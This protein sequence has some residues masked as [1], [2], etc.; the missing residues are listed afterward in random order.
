MGGRTAGRRG[1]AS[2]AAALA[3]SVLAASCSVGTRDR[4]TT[5]AAGLVSIG[6]GLR[7]PAGLRAA[8][9]ATRLTSVS[10]LALDTRGRL[11]VATSS[12]SKHATDAVYVVGRAGATPVRV[13]AHVRGPLGLLWHGGTLYVASIGRVDAFSGLRGDRFTRR[14]RILDG[15]VPDGWNN[16]LVWTPGGRILMGVSTTCDDCIPRSRWAASIVSFRPDGSQLRRYAT[17]IRDGF[18]LAR[19]PASTTLLV[20]MNQRDDLGA[21]TPGDWLGL[22][23]RGEDWGFP[24]CYGQ[25]GAVCRGV[26][27]P[28]AV[29]DPHAAAGG[30]G[31]VTGELGPSVGTAALVAEWAR[32]KVVRVALQAGGRASGVSTSTFL[33]GLTSPLPVLVDRRADTLFVGDWSTGK[34]YAITRA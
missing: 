28:L 5:S 16:G 4:P 21:R 11:W 18:G 19:Y 33:T 24:A 9:Y 34:V 13:I 2:L 26:P 23:R 3:V 27:A 22:V 20:S 17:G 14:V 6:A 31:I 30:V 8:V 10:A 7:G 25:G 1:T 12:A 32:G 29:L 15:P